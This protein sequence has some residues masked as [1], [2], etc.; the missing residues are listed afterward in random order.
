MKLPLSHQLRTNEWFIE[1]IDELI[2][3]ELKKME[4]GN[5]NQPEVLV[6]ANISLRAIKKVREYLLAPS[7]PKGEKSPTK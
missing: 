3:I 7:E 6:Q 4:L 2:K 1:G 5:P